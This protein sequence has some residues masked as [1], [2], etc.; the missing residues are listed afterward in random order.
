MSVLLKMEKINKYFPGVHAL[1]DVD[2][3]VRPGEVHALIGENGAG[4]STLMKCLTGV[5]K[6]DSGTITFDGEPWDVKNPKESTDKGISIVHQEFNLMPALTV[7]ENIF[8]AREPRKG[9][10]WLMNDEE[11]RVQ[12]RELMKRVE[13]E[14]DP[15]TEVSYLST[16]HCQMV[17]ILRALLTDVK[18]LVLDEPTS[19]LTADETEL[20]FKTI[21]LLRDR[22]VA[23]IY[24]SHR[25]DEFEH[26]VDRVTVLRDGHTVGTANYKDITLNDMI[27]MMI[28]RE[29][30]EQYPSRNAK[31]GDVVLEA[32]NFIN[33][34][35]HD[36]SL[37]VR[38]GEIL[39]MSG[40][41]GAGRTEFCRA[42]YGADKLNSGELYLR[43]EKISIKSPSDAVKYG[44]AY[45]S[46]D[47]KR[48]GLMLNQGVDFNTYIANLKEY[49]HTGFVDDK[50][51]NDTVDSYIDRLEIK[52][53]SHKQ[54]TQYLS[55][56][57]QQKVLVARWL[58]K[59]SDVMIFDEP[60]RGIDVGSKYEIYKLMNQLAEA[61]HAIIMI[62]SEMQEVLG[63][64]DRIMVMYE[65]NVTG[66]VDISE[67]NQ[68]I[69][70]HMA[71]NT[72]EQYK[73]SL[74][75]EG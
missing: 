36:V 37:Y 35:L 19:S 38:S 51:I 52:T 39:G 22:G 5:Y 41:V 54:W 49:S 58:C 47:R 55:G 43:G 15:D 53:P 66:E 56:G 75:Q 24:I 74:N 6:A 62:S 71:S 28:G 13:F 9:G 40:L 34:K 59:K 16:A 73:A 32:K 14:L 4:K 23:I 48:D 21:R 50:A 17:E 10:G 2:L 57:N 69:L 7:K 65:G 64:S 12:C 61:G 18:L 30:T 31:I 25:L 46:E 45:L 72:Y 3:E 26:I 68:E 33:P 60:T 67:A 11:M 8:I 63:M 42:I 1:T 44:I 29:M 20:L 27:K 70:M